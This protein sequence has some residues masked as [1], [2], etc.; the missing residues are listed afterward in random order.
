MANQKKIPLDLIDKKILRLLQEDCSLSLQEIARKVGLS[1][2]PCWRRIELLEKRGVI[3]RRVA[4][5]SPE[6]LNVGVT[7]FVA[8]RAGSH[9]QAW[10]DKF[11]KGVHDIPEIV[12][13]YRMSGDTDYMLRVVVPDIAAYDAVYK[14]LIKVADLSDV[15]SSFAMERI[16]FTTALPLDYVETV[17]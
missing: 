13:F 6:L 10:L 17:D 8:V 2:T 14:R 5:L 9:T 1:A 12:E 16:K 3:A 11:A 15:S 7:V 4:L